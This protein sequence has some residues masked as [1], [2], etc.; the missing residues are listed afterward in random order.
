MKFELQ[1]FVVEAGVER[2]DTRGFNPLLSTE[3]LHQIV[4]NKYIG[5]EF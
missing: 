4:I 2:C 5:G 3:L 1:N